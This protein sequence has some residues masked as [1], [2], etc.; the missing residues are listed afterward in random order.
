MRYHTT[1]AWDIYHY[2]RDKMYPDHD[3]RS[4]DKTGKYMKER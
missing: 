1:D 2:L 4:L 3:T